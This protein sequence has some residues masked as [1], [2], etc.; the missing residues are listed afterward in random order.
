M[1]YERNMKYEENM[2]ESLSPYIGRGTWKNFKLVP[3]AEWEGCC[4]IPVCGGDRPEK[5]HETFQNRKS[6]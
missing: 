6:R 4:K 2:K 5:R 1:K 3:P